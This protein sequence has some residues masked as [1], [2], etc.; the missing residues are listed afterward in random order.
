[1]EQL[2]TFL[3][4]IPEY[5]AVLSSL[6]NGENTAVTGVGQINRSH[7]IAGLYR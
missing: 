5:T 4:A 2:L 3:K 1:M 6:Q 7:M